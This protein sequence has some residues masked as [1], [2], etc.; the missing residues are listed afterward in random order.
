MNEE[1]EP[2]EGEGGGEGR[3]PR[4][5]EGGGGGERKEQEEELVL[6]LLRGGVQLR[7]PPLLLISGALQVFLQRQHGGVHPL[8]LLFYLLLGLRHT[9]VTSQEASSS[10]RE[11]T[12]TRRSPYSR[13]TDRVE[14]R[15]EVSGCLLLLT[16]KNPQ[17]SMSWLYCSLRVSIS[18]SWH[19]TS[20]FN[21]P[22][23]AVSS[24]SRWWRT[25]SWRRRSMAASA[26]SAC[27][28]LTSC[29]EED[30]GGQMDRRAPQ[31]FI[32]IYS[33]YRLH[34][35]GRVF[36]NPP[37]LLL[38]LRQLIFL[39]AQTRLR[40]LSGH[41]LLGD[42]SRESQEDHTPDTQQRDGASPLGP[43]ALTGFLATAGYASFATN[44]PRDLKLDLGA[45]SDAAQG[46]AAGLLLR[47]PLGGSDAADDVEEGDRVG[48]P[49][50]G[51]SG[52]T[53]FLASRL[54][55]RWWSSNLSL[56]LAA[57]RPLVCGAL[58][59]VPKLNLL[60]SLL[61]GSREL[62]SISGMG[63]TILDGGGCGGDSEGESWLFHPMLYLPKEPVYPAPLCLNPLGNV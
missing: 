62:V 49:G 42:P 9:H 6:G 53:S 37:Q 8:A 13:G 30:R 40:P 56:C 35:E 41:S 31:C 46:T 15:A 5:E 39:E 26:R 25:S 29:G 3:N 32:I 16:P 51:R 23:R 45:S 27:R 57:L 24:R 38:K 59:G 19:S 63:T 28:V 18:L 12:A 48:E 54:F 36:R 33:K 4:R 47:P 43:P 60:M 52:W 50:E 14:T 44:F 7:L 34:R 11:H 22:F 20:S 1:E 10:G 61:M 58:A 17:L 2:E 55:D 21:A